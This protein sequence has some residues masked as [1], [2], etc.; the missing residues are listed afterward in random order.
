MILKSFCEGYKEFNTSYS[1][2]FNSYYN[3]IGERTLRHKRGDISRPTVEEI[4]E[5]RKYVDGEMLALLDR[6]LSSEIRDLIV[7]GLNHEQQHQEL[8]LTD[9]KY[10]LS[11]NPTYP[12][13]KEDFALT[14]IGDASENETIEIEGG[15]YEIGYHGDGFHFDNEARQTQGLS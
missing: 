9:L 2:L 15:L 4:F 5:Y 14:E 11:T 10:T 12:V 1:F 6:E 13:Y 3:T 7:L 8:F